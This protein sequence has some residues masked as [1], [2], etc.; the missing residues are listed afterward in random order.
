[1]SE[2]MSIIIHHDPSPLRVDSTG[3]VRIGNTRVLLDLVVRAFDEGATAEALIERFP[4]LSLPEVY[5]TFT[6]CLQHRSEVDA[7]LRQRDQDASQVQRIVEAAQE[8]WQ[9]IRG[10]LMRRRAAGEK[11]DAAPGN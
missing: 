10:R 5:A 6:Y 2:P 8:D 7:Y 11:R 3:D 4:S 9:A 1:M